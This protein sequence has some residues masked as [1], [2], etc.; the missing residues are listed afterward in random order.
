MAIVYQHKRLD[1]NTVFY[2]GI[3]KDKA[4][5]YSKSGRN[6][7]W[8][9]IVNKVDYSVTILIGEISMDEAWRLE[10]EL[11]SYYGR[12]HLGTGLLAN[13]TEGGELGYNRIGI[14]TGKKLSSEHREKL[15]QAKLGKKR[16]KHSEETKIKISES[17]KGK[18]VLDSTKEKL[19][20]I[21]MGKKHSDETKEKLRNITISQR[22]KQKNLVI[23]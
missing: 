15:R 9:N 10:M 23:P 14:W 8:H 5:A 4:R 22:A 16:P 3:G 11:I 13:V 1:T 2:V 17:H 6:K 7:H 12:T 18:I 20:A 21:N 19:R